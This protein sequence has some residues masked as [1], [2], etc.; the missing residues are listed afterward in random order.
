MANTDT[1][2][3]DYIIVGA[4]SA[5][6][7]IAARLSENPS[8]SVLLLE[9]GKSDHSIF[10][11][12]PSAVEE[13]FKK[14][15]HNWRY[16]TEPQ[17]NLAGRRL[18]TPRGKVL[19]GSSSLNGMIYIRGNALDY[20]RWEKEG[21][22]GWSYSEVLPYFRRLEN[23]ASHRNQYRGNDGPV[24]ILKGESKNPLYQTFIDAGLQAGF[25]PTEDCNGFQQE[26]F[27]L[28]DMNV[29][30]GVRANTSHAYLGPARK[31]PN[32][33]VETSA[34]VEKLNL[35][36]G[37]VRG[38]SYTR[39]GIR[40]SARAEVET[41]LCG[42]AI[43]TPKLMLASGLGP[44]DDLTKIGIPV[45]ADLPEV[46]HN[47]QDHLEVHVEYQCREPITLYS[48]TKF[49]NKMKIGAQWL[50]FKTGK[51]ATNHYESGAFVRS[52]PGVEHP[53]IQ[54]HFVPI[55]YTEPNAMGATEHGFR[56]HVGS[57][58]SQSKGFVK[59]RSSDPS[60][61]PLIDPKYMS[62]DADW[63]DM[64]TCVRLSR[65]IFGQKAFDPYRGEEIWPGAAVKSQDQI[66]DFIRNRSQSAYHPSGTCRMGSDE[67]SV[68]DPE[69]RVRGVDGL[70]IA[71]ASIMP[72]IIS[73]NLNATVMMIGEKASDIIA[74]TP[75]PSPI[76]APHYVAENWQ[77]ETRQT[78]SQE[79]KTK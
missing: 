9:A 32:L 79:S 11:R 51:G 22:T 70:R 40:S 62:T 60:D 57:M 17:E 74:G 43:N 76:K 39:N 59:L 52:S 28:F 3:Y 4:G 31:R 16:W 18:W 26:G 21:A 12:M 54:F 1:R 30:N 8:N 65:E 53:D 46:G 23:H 38:V 2:Q 63:D 24:R 68:V 42:G 71:D 66:D 5:G 72:S 34:H 41:I 35:E 19:G 64:R 33:T 7:I 75:P 77:S 47:L 55:C 25:P 61:A 73:G 58:R 10:I 49:I 45:I 48:D 20:E 29:D 36:K 6:A 69:C 56:V 13:I 78:I 50:F 37:T 14:Q 67:N 15:S 44:A 27:G